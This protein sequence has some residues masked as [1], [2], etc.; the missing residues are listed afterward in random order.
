MRSLV[1]GAFRYKVRLYAIYTQSEAKIRCRCCCSCSSAIYVYLLFIDFFALDYLRFWLIHA[2]V[3]NISK[4]IQNGIDY[5][6]MYWQTFNRIKFTN[7]RSS[8]W[9]FIQFC[10]LNI[11]NIE[12]IQSFPQHWLIF[13][14]IMDWKLLTP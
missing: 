2:W 10:G 3:G 12:N 7:F 6:A 11:M 8:E 13:F 9:H 1:R 4:V 5:M 14:W